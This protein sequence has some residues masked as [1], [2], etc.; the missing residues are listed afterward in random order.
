MLRDRLSKRRHGAS[1]HRQDLR[2]W[3]A[4]LGSR[5][6]ARHRGS[7]SRSPSPS[8]SPPSRRAGPRP[9]HP[10][11]RS[12]RAAA[13][14]EAERA[15]LA[16]DLEALRGES[17]LPEA[18]RAGQR[19]ALEALD[20]AL[21]R[22]LETLREAPEKDAGALPEEVA[23]RLADG[24]PYSIGDL[25]AVLDAREAARSAVARL[26]AAAE[27]ADAEVEA[28][29]DAQ[30]EAESERRRAREALETAA[31]TAPRADARGRAAP[32]RAREPARRGG[33]GARPERTREG[34]PRPR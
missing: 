33:A 22:Q 17:E 30:E 11:V 6:N 4:T 16:K 28:A 3:G 7:G 27:F 1:N 14:L 5:E 2:A 19:E 26:D 31:P 13:Q 29:R 20:R 12:H 32:Q 23:R 15:K 8:P 34:P 21:L 9:G 24:A 25:D 10:G 18:D